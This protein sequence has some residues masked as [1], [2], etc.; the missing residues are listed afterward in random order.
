MGMSPTCVCGNVE[1]TDSN[2][3]GIPLSSSFEAR[4]LLLQTRWIV[5]CLFC[6]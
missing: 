5:S 2:L 1:P 6:V 4:S 3:A